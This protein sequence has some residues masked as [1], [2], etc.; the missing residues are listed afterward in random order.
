V[1][2]LAGVD[3]PDRVQAKSIL[4]LVNVDSNSIHDIVVTSAPL[5]EVEQLSKTV[6]ASACEVVEISPNSITDGE[7]DL[8]YS[9]YCQ[10]VEL[11]RT[12]EDLGHQNNIYEENKDVAQRL[13]AKFVAL[14][15][16]LGT[17]EDKLEPRRKI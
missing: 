16:E 14:L 5:E 7:W 17:S 1:L 2:E 12:K 3:I 9:V 11:Y 15:E 6:D 10:L 13:H 8:L 4:P